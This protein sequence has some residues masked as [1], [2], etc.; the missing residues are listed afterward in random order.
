MTKLRDLSKEPPFGLWTVLHRCDAPSGTAWMCRCECG[1]EKRVYATHLVRGKSQ[2]CHKCFS[3]RNSGDKHKQFTG[4]G[5]I[6]GEFWTD[7]QKG[8]NG[9]KGRGRVL[10]F[11][12]SIEYAWQLFIK[13]G[14]KCALSGIDLNMNYRSRGRNKEPHTASLDRI[15]SS[16]GYIEG[17][18][19]WVHK[20]I[21]IMK[22]R[23]SDD[24]FIKMCKL[25]AEHNK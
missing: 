11:S 2:S 4:Y 24:Y 12:I 13:Q 6:A 18:V 21:N 8:A 14:K 10:E 25:I 17:N 16:K 7:I 9:G 20:H 5:E 22:G 19:Q 15:D 3:K 23:H 1:L